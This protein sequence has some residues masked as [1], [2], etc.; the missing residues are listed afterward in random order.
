MLYTSLGT[1]YV[2][3]CCIAVKLQTVLLSR[4]YNQSRDAQVIGQVVLWQ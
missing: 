1:F 2:I 3:S 4:D